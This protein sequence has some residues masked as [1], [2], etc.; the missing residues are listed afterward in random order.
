[1]GKLFWYKQY[2]HR[3]FIFA[4]NGE[5][6]MFLLGNPPTYRYM[7]QPLPSLDEIPKP[8]RSIY[9]F[10]R[11]ILSQFNIYLALIHTPFI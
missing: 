7:G 3:L 9:V 4:L 6:K 2:F 10:E 5:R 8:S 11:I 1:M